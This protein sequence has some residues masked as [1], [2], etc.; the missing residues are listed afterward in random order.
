M[1]RLGSAGVAED[2][3]IGLKFENPT[4]GAKSPFSQ[5]CERFLDSLGRS[6]ACSSQ[7]AVE[8]TMVYRHGF[9]CT[10]FLAKSATEKKFVRSTKGGICGVRTQR[11]PHDHQTGHPV[12]TSGC[13]R[14]SVF[15]RLG[16]KEG[17]FHSKTIC[18]PELL[19][20]TAV[21]FRPHTMEIC[22]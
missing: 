6:P 15:E 20:T 22:L 19:R 18:R 21:S 8:F 11:R 17:F 4:P 1:Q 5:Q 10:T 14:A 9:Q 7:L 16:N 13:R 12:E 2:K 3:R